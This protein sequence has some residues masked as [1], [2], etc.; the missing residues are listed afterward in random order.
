MS[1]FIIL[2][3]K[4][5][6]TP[7]ECLN[8]Y[9]KVHKIVEPMTYAGRLDPMASDYLLHLLVKNVKTKIITIN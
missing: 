4:I 5:G 1:K 8:R 2:D 6:E 9:K 3:K 7:L